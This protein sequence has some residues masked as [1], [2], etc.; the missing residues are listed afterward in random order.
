MEELLELRQNKKAFTMFVKTF[1]KP[2]YSTKWKAKRSQQN[3]KS[4]SEIVTVSDEAFV[5][6]ALENNWERWIDINNKS[7]NACTASTR[8]DS[9]EIDS[10]AMPKCTCVNKKEPTTPEETLRR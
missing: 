9:K 7:Q 8:G 2:A 10:H 6:M 4:L 1:L 5:L 3:I